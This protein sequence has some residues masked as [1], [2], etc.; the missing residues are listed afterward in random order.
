MKKYT[1]VDFVIA[2]QF[3]EGLYLDESD[4]VDKETTLEVLDF[5]KK[6]CEDMNDHESLLTIN[7]CIC[8]V[9]QNKYDSD[10]FDNTI[11]ICYLVDD[12]VDLGLYNN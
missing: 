12:M 7:E 2:T 9:E 4:D 6:V 10:L 1:K 8:C 5:M 11:D 3:L